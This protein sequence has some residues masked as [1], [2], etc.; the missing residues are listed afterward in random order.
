VC[1]W[2]GGG[3][4]GGGGGVHVYVCMY[5]CIGTRGHDDAGAAARQHPVKNRSHPR[6]GQARLEPGLLPML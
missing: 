4:M 3:G 1:V 6:S 2:G 5:V